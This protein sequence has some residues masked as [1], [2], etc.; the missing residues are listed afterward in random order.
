[1]C[2]T[3]TSAGF[4]YHR[5]FDAWNPHGHSCPGPDRVA[6]WEQT[7][8]PWILRS[9]VIEEDDMPA[10]KDWDA[11]DWAAFATK[12]APAIAKAVWTWDGFNNAKDKAKALLLLASGKGNA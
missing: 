10:P 7:I 6:Q 8:G 11:D 4:G 1:M 12:G 9:A 2:P 3:P 5:M